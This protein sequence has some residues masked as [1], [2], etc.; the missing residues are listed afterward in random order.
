M[1]KALE[2]ELGNPCHGHLAWVCDLYT[3]TPYI[4]IHH[5]HK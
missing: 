4:D 2:Q 1:L 5:N 3:Q